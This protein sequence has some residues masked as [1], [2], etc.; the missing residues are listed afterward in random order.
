LEDFNYESSF[1]LQIHGKEKTLAFF[2]DKLTVFGFLTTF[3][4]SILQTDSR[5]INNFIQ[6]LFVISLLT[7]LISFLIITY[8]RFNWKINEFWKITGKITLSK[9]NI[10]IN[11]DT[12]DFLEIEKI[13]LKAYS[14]RG[15]NRLSDGSNNEIEIKTTNKT[16]TLKF[17]LE[18][19]EKKEE[20]KNYVHFLKSKNIL[21]YVEGI[22]LK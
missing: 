12:I 6:N 21:I 1:D 18:N 10:L 2:L 19:K 15:V 22:D 8:I 14:T 3:V 16:F 9:K 7:G 4:T 17:I 5:T 20:L 11:Y 13:R